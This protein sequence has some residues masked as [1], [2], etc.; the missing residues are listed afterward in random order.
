MGSSGGGGSQTVNQIRELPDF[1]KPYA[2]SL[3]NTGMQAINQ[4]V[5][6]YQGQRIAGM[7]SPQQ[8]GL[9]NIVNRATYGAPDEMAAR[10]QATDTLSG[11]YLSSNPAIQAP[12]YVGTNPYAGANSYLDSL[13]SKNAGDMANA[14]RTGI[15]AQTDAAASRDRSYGGSAYQD[16]VQRNQ[17]TLAKSLGDMA[18]QSRFQDYTAQQGLAENALNRSVQAQQ[19]DKALMDQ[20]YQGER[21][22][23]LQAINS[24]LQGSQ[25]DYTNAQ[26]M[27]G[28]GDAQRSY[29]Q[30]L[31][32]QMYQDYLTQVNK[33]FESIDRAG[34]LLGLAIG[35]TGSQTVR[36]AA[37]TQISPLA[38]FLGGGALGYGLG[39]NLTSGAIGGGLGAA[40][41]Y[42]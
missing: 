21:N 23:Q 40:L 41:S 3:L 12:T 29:Q 24:G 14:Y 28:A 17:A 2:Q 7:S 39:G 8:Q 42:L 4:P 27:I 26:Q 25:A 34:N 1:A 13:I 10:G 22:R 15:A 33:P 19:S 37:P 32:D 6:D 16:Q 20:A 38:G 5:Q 35:N 11:A 9:Q 30:S 31:L 18:L 36:T